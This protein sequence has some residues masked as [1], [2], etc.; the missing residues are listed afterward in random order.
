MVAKAATH[1]HFS[2]VPVAHRP[3]PPTSKATPIII[4]F[5]VYSTSRPVARASFVESSVP[6]TPRPKPGGYARLGV[7]PCAAASSTTI[8]TASLPSG[9]VFLSSLLE[10][11][12]FPGSS[13]V[14]VEPNADLASPAC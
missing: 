5:V 4:V 8:G 7:S 2:R 13:I 9:V 3:W 12:S 1:G 10:E 6:I 11:S 14:S